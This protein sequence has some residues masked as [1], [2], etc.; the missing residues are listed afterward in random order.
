VIE[1]CTEAIPAFSEAI[2]IS[3]EKKARA[4]A[5]L[6]IAERKI[7]ESEK[8][9]DDAINLLENSADDTGEDYDL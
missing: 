3:A 7:S 5:A 1:F 4:E 6:E 2:K 8:L 9:V